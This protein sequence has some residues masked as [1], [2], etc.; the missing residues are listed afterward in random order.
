[1]RFTLALISA[2]TAFALAEQP[3]KDAPAVT[4][5][6][7]TAAATQGS[8]I[9]TA[10]AFPDDGIPWN[11]DYFNPQ[12]LVRHE[13]FDP[14]LKVAYTYSVSFLSTPV[15]SISQN[16]FLAH[17][18]YEFTPD[19]H[20]YADLGLW[21]PFRST[22]HDGPFNK[23]D[24]RQG[25]PQFVLPAIALEYKP[26]ENSYLRLVL[27][28]EKDAFRAYGPSRLYGPCAPWRESIWCR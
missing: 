25:Q 7:T 12:K 27:L 6:D 15:G 8:A 11:R 28:N 5:N 18:A 9:D 24:M 23:E 10:G 13:T 4:A 1:M 17:L 2:L 16:S 20:L 21:M 26:T 22:F 14:A 19:L 3:A